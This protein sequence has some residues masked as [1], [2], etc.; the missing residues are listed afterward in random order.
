MTKITAAPFGVTK[1]GTEVS[2]YTLANGRGAEVDICTYG[3]AIV[4]IRVP[5]RDGKLV[6]VAL[7]YEDASGYENN[8]GFLGAL[9]GRVGNRIG[10]A[11]FDLNGKTYQLNV[12]DGEP[13]A[14]R[15]QGV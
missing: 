4:A 14:R 10:G 5:G 2:L 1:N 15:V 3:G 6:D 11:K 9:I 12:N 8:G 7:G 13:S